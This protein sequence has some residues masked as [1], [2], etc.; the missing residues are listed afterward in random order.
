[1]TTSSFWIAIEPNENEPSRP[2]AKVVVRGSAPHLSAARFWSRK[3]SAND[4]ISSVAGLA[5]PTGRKAMRSIASASSDHDDERERDQ[6][7]RP[8]AR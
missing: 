7:R 6:Q 4:V 3:L 8:A 5:A 1:M 2:D